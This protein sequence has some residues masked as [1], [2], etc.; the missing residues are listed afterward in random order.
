MCIR[1]RTSR[2]SRGK[3]AGPAGLMNKLVST[4]VNSEIAKLAFDIV[5][6]DGLTDPESWGHDLP[7]GGSQMWISQY[8]MT[9]GIAVAGGTANIQ[10][11]V[12]GERGYGLPRDYYAQRSSGK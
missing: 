3:D 5:G 4:N 6:E 7:I 9:L 10:R 1:D 12:I 8:M 11:N 2:A